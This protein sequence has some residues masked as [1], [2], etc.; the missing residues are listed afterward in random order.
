MIIK[1]IKNIGRAIRL[2]FN[3]NNQTTKI[4]LESFTLFKKAKKNLLKYF[5]KLFL[6]KNIH[7][8]K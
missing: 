2:L 4:L 3:V 7:D 1:N 6:E 5:V 8:N